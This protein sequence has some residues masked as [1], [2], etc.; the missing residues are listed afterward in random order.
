MTSSVL[1]KAQIL[2][3]EIARSQELSELRNTERLMLADEDAQ[4]LIA[5]FQEAQQ[6]LL[7]LQQSGQSPSEDDHSQVAS[8]EDRVESH[9][10]IAPYLTAQDRFTEMLDSVNAL[11]AQAIAGESADSCSSGCGGCSGC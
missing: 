2:A 9:P 10:L 11:L 7:E 1:E 3:D 5:E 8:I 6:R 4:R